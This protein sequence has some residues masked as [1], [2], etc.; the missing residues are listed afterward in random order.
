VE[1]LDT[2]VRRVDEDRWLASRFAPERVR[3]R[4]IALYALNYEIA[5]TPE[6]VSQPAL[7]DIRLEWWRSG[8]EELAEGHGPRSHPTLV[9]LHETGRSVDIA[10]IMMEVVEARAADFEASPFNTWEALESYVGRT[11]RA[12]MWAAVES[13]E[14]GGFGAQPS[15][16]LDYAARAWGLCGLMRAEPYWRARGR[17]FLPEGASSSDVLERARAAYEEARRLSRGLPAA[18]FPAT[19]YVALV[20][21]YLRVLKQGKRERALFVRQATLLRASATGVI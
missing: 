10:R 5:R 13:S 3:Q 21:A 15:R 7:G 18:V 17:S 19:G 2:L 9:A 11:A 8:L 16:F 1:D 14:T 20:P 12:V 6:T 4:L